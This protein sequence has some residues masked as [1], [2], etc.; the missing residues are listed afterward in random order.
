[1]RACLEC[2]PALSVALGVLCTSARLAD[3]QATHPTAGAT[4]ASSC[5]RVDAG[6]F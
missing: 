6:V 4:R 3:R 1:V 2:L 5:I